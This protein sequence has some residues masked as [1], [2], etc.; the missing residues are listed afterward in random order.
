MALFV[1]SATIQPQKK[2]KRAQQH[3]AES[4]TNKNNVENME[5]CIFPCINLTITVSSSLHRGLTLLSKQCFL[6]FCIEQKLCVWT[7]KSHALKVCFH[8]TLWHFAFIDTSTMCQNFFLIVQLFFFF[9]F[10]NL[11]FPLENVH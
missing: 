6:L 8:C 9:F 10:S 7:W 4:R 1:Q 2:K 11:V 5:I 3:D